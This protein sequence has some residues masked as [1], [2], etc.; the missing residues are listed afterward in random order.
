MFERQPWMQ[1][2]GEYPS[3]DEEYFGL[4]ARTVFSAGLGPRVVAARWQT[5]S[6][7]FH[8][9]DPAKIVRMEEADVTRLLSDPGVIRNRRKIEAVIENAR[10]YLA[11]VEREGSFHQYLRRLFGDAGFGVVVD[12][13]SNTFKHLGPTSAALFLF[14]AGWRQEVVPETSAMTADAET[15]HAK[16]PAKRAKPARA[17]SIPS[18]PTRPETLAAADVGV[19]PEVLL[20]TESLAAASV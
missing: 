11:L 2:A 5:L 9:F 12:E 10:V 15:S 1:R 6:V 19:V 3:G 20:G 8:A 17:A 13:L 16:R 4:L 7:A 14:S 18:P